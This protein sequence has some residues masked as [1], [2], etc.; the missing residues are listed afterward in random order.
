MS[1][2]TNIPLNKSLDGQGINY[3]LNWLLDAVSDDPG[4]AEA[5]QLKFNTADNRLKYHDGNELRTL[6]LLSDLEPFALELVIAA[7]E[8]ADFTAA[9]GSLHPVNCSAEV[10]TV[11]PPDSPTAGDRFGV[12]D[13]RA[14]SDTNKITVDFAGAGQ[15]LYGSPD[16]FVLNEAGA[17]TEFKYLG[18]AIGWIVSK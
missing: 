7:E 15:S 1:S 13:S 14:T 3:L 9:V 4:L 6:A 12:V 18:G 8:T 11:N 10:V 17:Y 5:L 2:S 16:T